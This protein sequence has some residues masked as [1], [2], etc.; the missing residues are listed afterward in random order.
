M[1]GP[2]PERP[3]V[4]RRLGIIKEPDD[5]PL[6]NS[7]APR[8]TQQDALELFAT[9]AESSSSVGQWLNAMGA[10]AAAAAR[11]AGRNPM[12]GVGIVAVLAL[13][14]TVW[15]INQYFASDASQAQQQAV[16]ATEDTDSAAST[17]G[18]ATTPTGSSKRPGAVN[19]VASRN[20]GGANT[21]GQQL[22]TRD[23]RADVATTSTTP[24]PV[25]TQADRVNAG[26]P[27]APASA[28]AAVS[29]AGD[30]GS[31]VIDET[32]YSAQDRDVVPPRASERLPAPTFSE[33]TTRSNE[34]EVIVSET[35]AVERV[36]LV[37]PPQRMPD[38]LVLSRAKMWKFT[39]AMKDGKPVR[40]RLLM[41]WEVNP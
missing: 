23:R 38:V 16:T 34:M 32:I 28:A 17:D 24:V 41:T 5:A 14:A 11:F 27:I 3:V 25:T 36:R 2:S 35:G 22:I 4:L 19:A 33:W 40:Y 9:E 21:R 18:A 13:V 12:V 10:S 30:A 20:A 8:Q 7:R 26:A 31:T 29:P 6:Q 39:P 1:A 37:T 15:A